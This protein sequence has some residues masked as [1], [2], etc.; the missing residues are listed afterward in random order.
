MFRW[1]LFLLLGAVVVLAAVVMVVEPT[2]KKRLG[3]D[4]VAEVLPAFTLRDGMTGEMLGRRDLLGDKLLLNVWATWCV[5]CREEHPFLETLSE[6]GVRIVG[7]YYR[8]APA[9][10]DEWLAARGNPYVINLLD[11]RGV[12]AD[13]LPVRGAPE[14]YFVDSRGIFV[15]KY[16]GVVSAENW[17]QLNKIYSSMH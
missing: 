9:S 8:D 17:P 1:C 13:R 10:A 15:Y 7:L 11:I 14:T 4:E 12:L 16:S 5:A 2:A 3:K 6:E